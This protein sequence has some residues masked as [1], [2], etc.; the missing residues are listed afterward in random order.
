MTDTAQTT[1]VRGAS[2]LGERPADLVIAGGVIAEI[3]EPGAASGDGAR[4]IEAEGLIALPGFVDPHTHLRE[5]GKEEAETIATGARAAAAG[6]YTAVLAMANTTPVTDT[7][8]NAEWV[9]DTGLRTPHADVHPVGA[10]TKGLLGEGLAELWLMHT[11]RAAVNVFSDDGKCVADPL[12][13]RRALEY[14]AAFGGVI[15]QHSQDPRLAPP[16]SCCDEGPV[17][18]RL[19]LP[20]WPA[21]AEES[22]VAR[23]IMLAKAAGARLHICHLSTAGSV[24][25]VR[26]GKAQGA[27]VTAEV[28]PHHLALTADLL[29]SYDSV[30]KVNPPLRSG[31]DV[32]ALRAGLADG[33]I[34]MI[35]TDH[36]PHPRRDKEHDFAV[37]AFG[38]LGLETALAVV[39]DTMV[40]AGRMSWAEV[41][42]VM[43]VRPA[44]LAGLRDQGRPLVAGEPA[45]IA[46]VDPN[47]VVTVDRDASASKSR[48]NPWHGAT[49][50]GRVRHTLL[51][52]V[53]TYLD[54][55]VVQFDGSIAAP[56][57][58]IQPTNAHGGEHE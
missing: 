36:A 26:R 57:P 41:A 50:R 12:L 40:G 47:A 28:T 34:D 9:F 30:Y 27:C 1:I 25:L 6:G 5:P 21:A 13:M 39:A 56:A 3:T 31:R 54:G 7:A 23:D 46:L 45:T 44:R 22:I 14:T 42:E 32:E 51:R 4:L 2:L 10:V 55:R 58:V 29:E 17:S 48:N 43:S 53:P 19:G 20:G 8:P 52:G 38:M 11:S 24:E 16:T 18:G 37:A 35:G 33:T 15:A 49:L